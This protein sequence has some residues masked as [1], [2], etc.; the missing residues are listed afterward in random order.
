MQAAYDHYGTDISVC[1]MHTTTTALTFLQSAY[2]HCGTDISVCSLYTTI[3]A[4]TFMQACSLHT[5]VCRGST[6]CIAASTP[7]VMHCNPMELAPLM[8]AYNGIQAAN[9]RIQPVYRCIQAVY[10]P[11][12]A[13]A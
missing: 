2:D 7:T 11:S 1:R 4:L 9:C 10:V 5:I 3:T 12:G 13:P 6:L 8:D